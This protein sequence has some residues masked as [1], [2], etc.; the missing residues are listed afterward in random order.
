MVRIKNI[1]IIIILLSTS[2][3]LNSCYK[4]RFD[5]DKIGGGQWNP[6]IAAP[7]VK[8]R[9]TMKDII[10]NSTEEWKEYP[11][12][13]LSLIYRQRSYSTFADSTVIIPDQSIDTNLT[14]VL[15]PSMVPGD[16]TSELFDIYASLKGN[17]NEVLDTVFFKSGF[18]D[19]EISTD[20]NHDA[21]IDIIIPELTKYGVTFY[22]TVKIPKSNGGMHTVKVSFP[23]N[24]YT[25]VFKHP[26]GND[27]V[28]HQFF[29][30]RVNFGVAANNSPYVLKIKQGLSKVTYY[31]ASGYFGKYNFIADKS[32]LGISLFDNSTVDQIF[33]EDPKLHLS[34]YNSFGIPLNV[35]MDEFY[36]ERD[37]VTK[38]VIS[39]LLPDMAI[40]A[41]KKMYDFDTTS[42]LFD[43]NNSNITDLFNFQPKKVVFKET[44]TTNP[45][46]NPVYN[47][48]MD[49]SR[50]YVNA[51]IE[52]PLY[53]R[54]LNFTV[55]DS[56]DFSIK[57][58][59]GVISA[60]L[61]FNLS[62]L[63]PSEAKVQVYLADTN[64]VILDS[65]LSK[66]QQILVPA[67]VGPPPDYRTS[68]PLNQT[69]VVTLKGDKLQHFWDTKKIIF[70]ASLSTTEQGQKVVKIY[71]DYYV[72]IKMAVKLNYMTEL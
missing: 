58:D 34:F 1:L 43:K 35:H 7:V 40:D 67:T 33:L 49:T 63:F 41:A 72:D 32:V 11:D 20:L 37:G 10:E 19:V 68:T 54:A 27:N 60:D 18:M 51:E 2:L 21:N 39:T 64:Y 50:V 12:G 71:S 8:S 36:V 47:F 23:L 66:D 26:N 44:F 17:N 31:N 30:A 29:K 69:T 25:A 57:K 24:L 5:V 9:L 15:P 3:L 13:L 70:R 59:E 28:L 4:K 52:L 56:S 65:L 61:R 16:S 45:S 46:G 48:L 14:L 22:K 38:D 55:Q 62:N 6:E 42:Y 53:G